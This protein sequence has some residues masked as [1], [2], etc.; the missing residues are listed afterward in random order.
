MPFYTNQQSPPRRE[1]L[2]KM[3]GGFKLGDVYDATIEGIKA[4]DGDKSRL[5]MT[6]FH[7]DQLCRTSAASG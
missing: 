5:G 4:Q 6:A 7:V 1:K 3:A 2:R